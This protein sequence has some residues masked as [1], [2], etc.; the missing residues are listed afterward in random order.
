M[1]THSPLPWERTLWKVRGADGLIAA[2]TS[3]LTTPDALA[4]ADLIV[5]A[6]NSHAALLEVLLAIRAD[7][8]AY[9][10]HKAIDA[11]LAEGGSDDQ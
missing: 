2:E 11:A 1:A 4:N 6:V 9:Q 3:G 5:R 8:S 10:W 7:A